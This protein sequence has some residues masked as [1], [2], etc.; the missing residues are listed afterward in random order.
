MDPR[1][2]SRQCAV[3]FFPSP[4]ETHPPS[5]WSCNGGPTG[6]CRPPGAVR[7]GVAAEDP[8]FVGRESRYVHRSV[9]LDQLPSP[10]PSSEDPVLAGSHR[11]GGCP[12]R[13][14][15][16]FGIDHGTVSKLVN[17]RLDGFSLERLI[18]YL[19]ALGQDVEITI[20]GSDPSGDVGRLM[21]RRP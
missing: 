1:G 18:R 10:H 15:E 2:P 12:L 3:L 14:S 21:N 17:D 11:M 8:T 6:A 5:T 16:I 4:Q 20:G 13:G 19:N 9:V 7:V